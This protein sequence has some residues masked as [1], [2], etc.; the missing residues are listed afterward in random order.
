MS[1]KFLLVLVLGDIILSCIAL[2]TASIMRFGG[3]SDLGIGKISVLIFVLVFSSFFLEIYNH[4]KPRR[5]REIL[6]QILVAL[7]VSLITLSAVYYMAPSARLWRGHLLLTLLIFG[8]LQF[9]WHIGYSML[10]NIP[11][12]AKRVLILGTGPLAKRMGEVV[13]STNH[14]HVLGGYVNVASEPI[15]VP[16]HAIVGNGNGLFETIKEE[17]A[18]KLVVS[19]S[20][21]RGVFPLQDVLNCKFSGI[22]IIDAPSFYEELTGKLLIENMTPSSLIFCQGFKLNSSM[23]RF[24]RTFD[25]FFSIIG[26]ILALPFVPLIALMIKIDSPGPVFLKQV[27]VGEREKQFILYKFRTMFQDAENG[28]GA[29][30]AQKNDHRV[31]R[32]GRFLRKTRLDEIPQLYNVLRGDMS[33]IG[34]RPERPEFI[35]KLKEIIPYYSERHFV[36]PG[37]T[38]WAQVKYPYGASVEDAIEKL[39]Y[40][41]YYMKHLSLFFDLLILLETI[42]VVMFGRG[43][44]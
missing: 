19:L 3:A 12:L 10:L 35:E 23:K 4:D 29:V 27:R 15:Q 1:K 24:K 14:H 8:L 30:W 16:S 38:G 31:T 25:L 40:D 36:K 42:K 5:K 11:G 20:E 33:F 7:C 34:P 2:Y 6:I 17:R 9:I 26:F 13:I 43:G 18:H 21:Q 41:L 28:T 39:R 44:R 32:V 22:E 37:I